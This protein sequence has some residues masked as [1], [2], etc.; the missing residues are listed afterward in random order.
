M[1]KY[2]TWTCLFLVLLTFMMGFV[3]VAMAEEGIV[4]FAGPDSEEG[5]TEPTP[6]AEPTPTPTPLP[7]AT[8]EPTAVPTPT[9]PNVLVEAG[10]GDKSGVLFIEKGA[11][12]WTVTGQHYWSEIPWQIILGA[13]VFALIF[14]ALFTLAVLLVERTRH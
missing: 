10:R 6:T 2:R 7:T 3:N 13:G 12:G 9:P 1:K 4:Y 14:F 8:P 11:E 5:D